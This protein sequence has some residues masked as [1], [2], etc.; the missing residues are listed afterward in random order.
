[1]SFLYPRVSRQASSFG[2]FLVWPNQL[3]P[4]WS[5]RFRSHIRGSRILTS[6]DQMLQA[7]GEENTM[8]PS[9]LEIAAA[10]SENGKRKDWFLTSLDR[11]I[12][13]LPHGSKSETLNRFVRAVPEEIRITL[14]QLTLNG[15]PDALC[16]LVH[17]HFY[18]E[19]LKLLIR[20]YINYFLF[21]FKKN[22]MKFKK[23]LVTINLK[24][25]FY[26]RFN[27]HE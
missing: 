12:F 9:V 13:S 14:N 1:M 6:T 16:M 23:L 2:L 8:A 7:L 19:M 18:T 10:S 5:A 21:L 24:P 20:T 26:L 15:L 3:L 4:C 25:W 22:A 17:P 27:S 11:C